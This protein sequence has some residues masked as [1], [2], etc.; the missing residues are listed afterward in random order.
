MKLRITNGKGFYFGFKNN[1]GISVQFG[2]GSYSD[3]YDMRIGYEDQEAGKAGSN[4]AEI[5]VINPKGELFPHPDFDGDTVKGWISPDEIMKY[6]E[7]AM[8]QPEDPSTNKQS[9]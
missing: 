7:F 5:A 6:M 8:N 9:D 3:N 2:P 1:W 4:T